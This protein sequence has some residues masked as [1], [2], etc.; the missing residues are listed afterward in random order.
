[1]SKVLAYRHSKKVGEKQGEK[2]EVDIVD[3]KTENGVTTYTVKTQDGIK[4]S[5]IFNIFNCSYYADDIYGVIGRTGK[6]E[7]KQGNKF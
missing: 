6:A 2:E 1:M 7:W 3:F 5:A 4:C